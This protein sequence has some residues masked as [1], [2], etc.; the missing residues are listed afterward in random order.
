MNIQ[1]DKIGGE[2]QGHEKEVPAR[3]I[4]YDAVAGDNECIVV[5]R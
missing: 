1:I 5:C 3:L 2:L 4:D